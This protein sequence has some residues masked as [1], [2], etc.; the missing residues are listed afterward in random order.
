M[1]SFFTILHFLGASFLIGGEPLVAIMAIKAEKDDTALRF[2]ADFVKTVAIFMWVGMGLSLIG[3]LGMFLNGGYSLNP[4]V[5]TKLVIYALI[6]VVSLVL[7]LQI[8]QVQQTAKTNFEG[9]RN[10]STF[11]RLDILSRI[12]ML[13]V[14]S[15]LVISVIM[16]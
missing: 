6:A 10:D 9:L 2:F 14:M 13:L 4:L 8:P 15:I 7:L 5:V 1:L 12:D 3:G 16:Y 11:K